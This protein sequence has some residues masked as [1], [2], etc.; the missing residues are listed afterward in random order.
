METEK[1]AS[2]ID[3]AITAN[4][5]KKSSFGKAT[6]LVENRN[7]EHFT[8]RIGGAWAALI[9]DRNNLRKLDETDNGIRVKSMPIKPEMFLSLCQFLMN[10]ACWSA[11]RYIRADEQTKIGEL[12]R[13]V[14]GVDFSQDVA[15]EAGIEPMDLTEIEITLDEDFMC[16]MR[17]H[18][19]MATKM[20]YLSN[21]E[22]LYLFADREQEGEVWKLTGAAMTFEE[23][24][25]LM[26]G[27]V[28]KMRERE[29]K[30]LTESMTTTDFTG[31]TDKAA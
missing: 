9:N 19:Y 6:A 15:E 23:A 5:I 7:E 2:F 22:D 18:S 11:R 21:I 26:D 13:G 4:S 24:R 12:I 16:M 28:I 20:N 30:N 14:T 3:G 29:E 17:L 27:T 25:D 1:I 31:K 10:Q 8:N